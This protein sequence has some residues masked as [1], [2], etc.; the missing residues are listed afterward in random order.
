[1]QVAAQQGAYVA[2]LLNR[3]YQLDLPVPTFPIDKG[4]FQLFLHVTPIVS[5]AHVMPSQRHAPDLTRFLS[6]SLFSATVNPL[7]KVANLLRLRGRL[8]APEFSF[9]NLGLLAY[10]GQQ[11]VSSTC[12]GGRDEEGRWAMQCN[13]MQRKED[14]HS[15]KV[16]TQRQPPA[17]SHS[18]PI[19]K[20][21]HSPNRPSRRCRRGTS[22]S[23]PSP[24]GPATSCG[25]ACI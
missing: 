11:E 18:T 17:L 4:V 19:T 7:E 5:R 2:R 12:M 1:M 16:H 21:Y 9:L 20:S 13:S 24:R 8:E 3:G 22:S 25:V 15:D 23:A 14:N 10:V 6:P